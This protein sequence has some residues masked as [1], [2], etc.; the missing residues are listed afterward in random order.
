[1]NDIKAARKE[2]NGI[3][4][5]FA[6]CKLFFVLVG[7]FFSKFLYGILVRFYGENALEAYNAFLSYDTVSGL[8]L[9]ITISLL[10]LF[11]PICFYFACSRKS[12]SERISTERPELLQ[13]GYG[14]GVTVIVGNIS[15]NLGYVLLQFLFTLFGLE[16]KYHAMLEADTTYPKNFW[17]VPV[18]AVVLAVLPA[19][20]EEIL[21]R[22]IGLSGTKKFG[23]W[24]ALLFSG[25]FFSFMHNTWLQLPFAFV[26]GIVLAYFTL[27][28][29]TIWI[30]VISH[31]IFNFNSVIQSLIL[32]NGG[33]YAEVYVVIWGLLFTSLML[34]LAIA[35][36][37]VYG[38]RKP[39]IPKSAFTGWQRIKILLSSPFL[40]IFIALSVYQLLYL[41]TIY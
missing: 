15:A 14:V 3:L 13:I 22:G 5:L 18:F 23:T 16:D 40:Y 11:V 32:Q 10:V 27:R 6:L 8:F 26:L 1:M 38:I 12:F 29:N 9:E 41:L 34:G 7:R 31:F 2:L 17:L 30:A 24:F 39:P 36:A 19:F 35:G 20:L 28:F 21:M 4:A 33:Q 25:F 37:I